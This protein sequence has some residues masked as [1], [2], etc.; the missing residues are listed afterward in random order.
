MRS[1][2]FFAI[3]FSFFC[4]LFT[5]KRSKTQACVEKRD[6]KTSILMMGSIFPL[7]AEL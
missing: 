5:S 4:D 6:E 1:V 2:L 3:F 7:F